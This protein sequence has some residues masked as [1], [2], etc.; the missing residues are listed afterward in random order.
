[1]HRNAK[2]TSPGALDVGRRGRREARA[3]LWGAGRRVQGRRE[4]GRRRW[5]KVVGEGVDWVAD[6]LL[7]GAGALVGS[8]VCEFAVFDFVAR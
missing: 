3:T 2:T 7:P 6:F 8:D 5:H 1:M 4:V